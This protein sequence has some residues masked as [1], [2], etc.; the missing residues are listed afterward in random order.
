MKITKEK[1]TKANKQFQDEMSKHYT[2]VS[3]LNMYSCKHC[4][5]AVFQPFALLHLKEQ[6]QQEY[7][8][9]HPLWLNRGVPD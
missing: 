2:L 1:N 9:L 4:Y 7:D 3:G 8:I 5:C 6:H